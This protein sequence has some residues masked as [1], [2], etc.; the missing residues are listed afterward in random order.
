MGQ[1]SFAAAATM[2]DVAAG[3]SELHSHPGWL[4][5]EV[6]NAGREHL[7]A[8]HVARYDAKEDA[9]ATDEVILLKELGLG[10]K[11]TVVDFGAGTGQFALAAASACGRVVAVDVSSVMLERLHD[12]VS[13]ANL[14]NVEVVQ[15]GFLTYEHP[16]GPA[17]FVYSR[18]ALHHLPDFWKAVALER[19]HRTVQPGGVLRLWDVVYNFSPAEAKERIE[20][21][22]ATGSGD[23]ED[24]WSR[25]ELEEHVRD[26]HST[27]AWLLEPMLERSGFQIEEASY[28]SDGFVAKYI[29]RA[30]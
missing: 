15:A 16:G 11:S 19:V 12:K 27:F 26:E 17:D 18:Y 3:T 29:A 1:G 25:G 6:A 13:A 21:W 28:S 20:A 9:C 8:D 7:D 5:D 22:C 10:G 30:I 4:L 23:V 2:V 14:S 24:G